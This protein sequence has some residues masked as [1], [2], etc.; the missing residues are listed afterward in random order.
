MC[1]GPGAPA[2]LTQSQCDNDDR[3]N[4][5]SVAG[6]ES[7]HHQTDDSSKS[8]G[9]TGLPISGSST[10]ASSW[11]EARRTL[12]AIRLEYFKN[13][14]SNW[15]ATVSVRAKQLLFLSALSNC[16]TSWQ[17]MEKMRGSA[18]VTTISAA[19]TLEAFLKSNYVSPVVHGFD[20]TS[21]WCWFLTQNMPEGTLETP[22]SP[23][24]ISSIYFFPL[25]KY[26]YIIRYGLITEYVMDLNTIRGHSGDIAWHPAIWQWILPSPLAA[27]SRGSLGDLSVAPAITGKG[28]VPVYG[29]QGPPAHRLPDGLE[30][31]I[32]IM[33]PRILDTLVDGPVAGPAYAPTGSLR[34][35]LAP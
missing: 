30:T 35:P 9:E 11:E 12:P 25:R 21:G 28:H 31:M 19:T 26:G 23:S 10:L 4:Y 2:A 27:T 3:C 14:N 7:P 24:I 17:N 6:H 18:T 8:K 22:A 15:D 1:N 16:S 13:L 20:D 34:P 5:G 32:V 33:I 29:P